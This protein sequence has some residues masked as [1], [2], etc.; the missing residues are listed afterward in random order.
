MFHFCPLAH[1]VNFLLIPRLPSYLLIPAVTGVNTS[2]D[3][4]NPTGKLS[5]VELASK[6]IVHEIELPGQPDAVDVSK[7]ISSFPIYI[8]VAIENERDED[9]GDGAPPQLPAGLLT[10]TTIAS[11][12]A[13]ADPTS[14]T[15]MD[16]PLTGLE[17]CRFPEDPEPEYV[18]IHSDNKRVVVTL[19][20]NNCNVVVDMETGAV[21]GSF[22]A[23]AVALEGIDTIEDGLILQ[24]ENVP[25][26]DIAAI[27]R[28]SEGGILREPDGVSWIGSTNYFATAN[29]GDLDGGSR[30]WSIVDAATGEVV[31]DSGIEM[32]W[33]TAKSGHYPDERSGNK[34]NEPEN[35]FY[36]SF[37]DFGTEYVFVLSER[38]SVVFV[39]T[40]DSSS[41]S[42]PTPELVQILPVGLA[43]EGIT[44]IPSQNLVAIA[45]EKDERGDKFRSSIAVFELATSETGIPEYP[46]LISAPRDGG[47]PIPF[48]ALSGLSAD[49]SDNSILY[50]V[51]D[52]FYN[53]NRILTID[54]SSFPAVVVA[55]QAMMDSNGVLAECLT[56]YDTGDA[57]IT[58]IDV[59]AII[60]ED[61]T[62]NI[63]PEGISMV[64]ET[65]GFWVVSEGKGTVGDEKKPFAFPNLLLQLDEDATIVSCVVPDSS[66]QPQLRFGFE[67]VAE[68]GTKVA[69]A[70]QR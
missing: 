7:D 52:S 32:E 6:T 42:P 31:Y 60:N 12:E 67:G 1:F 53:K 18:A 45:S 30:G 65:G 51:E 34:G 63:D 8:A 40:I 14:W 17:G 21:L 10:V 36:E 61:S 28:T 20:E 22:D 47:A 27:G 4:V 16:F 49:L 33:E 39:Y 62:I 43:P 29:E 70:V 56:E 41:M 9:L 19:Q 13:L 2:P 54:A 26:T 25:E 37:P 11:E 57:N 66:F 5:V 64:S 58:Q 46:S 44:A 55:E 69:V 24:V 68:D 38:S 15:S 48:S 59:S 23:G 50:S 35:V 3:Y